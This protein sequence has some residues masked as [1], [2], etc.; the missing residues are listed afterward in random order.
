VVDY[1]LPQ[2]PMLIFICVV[3]WVQFHAMEKLTDRRIKAFNE[4]NEAMRLRF[5][6]RLDVIETRIAVIDA[7]R[8][9]KTK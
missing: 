6:S 2:L 3:S 7:A 5:E 1:I 9:G 8:T 4:R